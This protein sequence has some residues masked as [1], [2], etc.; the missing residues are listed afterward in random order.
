MLC[1]CLSITVYH[2]LLSIIRKDVMHHVTTPLVLLV[3]L[4]LFTV[5]QLAVCWG[6]YGRLLVVKSEMPC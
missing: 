5:R 3:I 1:H 2:L 4:L 6:W